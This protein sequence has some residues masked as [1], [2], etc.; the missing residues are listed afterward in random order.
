MKIKATITAVL[1]A[2]GAGGVHADDAYSLTSPGTT[3]TGYV[4]GT[5]SAAR[6]F[7]SADI[8]TGAGNG[9]NLQGVSIGPVV[10]TFSVSSINPNGTK[11]L[12]LFRKFEN[13]P[14]GGA[15]NAFRYNHNSQLSVS[16]TG[17]FDGNAV[18]I[19]WRELF[20]PRA[21]YHQ[22]YELKGTIP[23]ALIGKAG[24]AAGPRL[25]SSLIVSGQ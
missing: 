14:L 22:R 20:Q 4:T 10:R 1:L 21:P 24:F 8:V 5:K 17:K 11:I 15:D 12:N 6:P 7:P 23:S 19:S 2:T 9:V 18:E 16:G 25:W 3:L 13:T